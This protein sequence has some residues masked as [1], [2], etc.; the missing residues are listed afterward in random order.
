MPFFFDTEYVLVKY[1]LKVQ[2]V[3][4]VTNMSLQNEAFITTALPQAQKSTHG[5]RYEKNY[6]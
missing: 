5:T 3:T 1:I 4:T 2:A 6:V